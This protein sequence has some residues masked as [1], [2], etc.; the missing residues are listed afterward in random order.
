VAVLSMRA[1]KKVVDYGVTS[2]ICCG[3][4]VLQFTVLNRFPVHDVFCN[5]PLTLVIVWGAVFG[6]RMPP[7]TPDELRVS[8]LGQI[9]VRQLASGSMSGALVG[10]LMGSLYASILPVYPLY[11]AVI[12]WIA[13]YFCLRNINQQ[14]LLCVPLVF[15]LTGLAESLFA[16][17]LG[18]MGRPFVT[19]RLMQ[20]ALP[21]AIQ[22]ALIAPFIYF[23]MRR[24]YEVSE[25]ERTPVGI[26]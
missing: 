17:Q 13:G 14:N 21:E 16:L 1:R 5:L 11:F 9:F 22:N 20:I 26:D 24:W 8:T 25:V 23:P 15:I 3:A 18:L 10:A 6:S 12:G 4:I 2:V 19:D 7:I